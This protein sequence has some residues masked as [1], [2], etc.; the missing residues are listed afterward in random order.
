MDANIHT[1]VPDLNPGHAHGP[2]S[3]PQTH[4]QPAVMILAPAVS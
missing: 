3:R 2:Y 1:H 4:N